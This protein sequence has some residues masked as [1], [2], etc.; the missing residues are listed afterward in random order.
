MKKLLIS[1]I[2]EF[3]LSDKRLYK[4]RLKLEKNRKRRNQPHTLEVFIA[5]DDP[6]S[7]L[8][9]QVLPELKQRYNLTLKF[10]TVL[11][12]QDDM[13]PEPQ[14]WDENIFN[15]CV[16]MAQLYQLIKPKCYGLDDKLTKDVSLL[17][18]KGE[19]HPE[20]LTQATEIFHAAWQNNSHFLEELVAERLTTEQSSADLPEYKNQLSANEKD[21]IAQGH[22][23][24]GTLHYGGEWYWGLERLQYLEK[25]LNDLIPSAPQV[26]K[27]NKLHDLYQ[28]FNKPIAD[29]TS[30][31]TLYFS[32]RSPY[33]YLGLLRSIKLA[34]H[35]Q[36]PLELKPV[37]PML[38]R[39]MQVPKKKGI[40]IVLDTKREANS[41][42]IEFGKIADPLGEGVERCYALFEYAKSQ[43][44]EVEYMK[45]YAT[46]VWSQ[47]I[48]SNTNKGLEHIVKL[49]GLDW[50]QAQLLLKDESWRAWAD[51][52]LKELFSLGFW[53][54]PCFN[55]RD[56]SVFGQDK[57]LFIE[58]AIRNN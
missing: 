32:I 45:N 29:K 53:G 28:P 42:G 31:L 14:L 57:L 36:I 16:R 13:Y 24:S 56:T 1:Y 21:L 34:N 46:A 40:Y 26:I 51:S 4:K 2:S 6:A 17:L 8:L 5:I 18:L 43:G 41:Y 11:Q 12:K 23:L 27:Y 49:S 35:Y 9:L 3:I 58:Q 7:Y 48:F 54:V 38:M 10:K 25:R 19:N 37:L 52:N 50:H 22:F 33:S 44:K 39:G 47:R 15:D 55:Y 20:F 30:P